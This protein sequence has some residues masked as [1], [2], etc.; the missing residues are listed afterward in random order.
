MQ[1]RFLEA[2]EKREQDRM[3]REEAWKRQEMTRLTCKHEV[4]AKENAIGASMDA[5]IISFLQ[6]ITS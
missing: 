6:K 1:Q 5:F 3:I 4:M 2:I